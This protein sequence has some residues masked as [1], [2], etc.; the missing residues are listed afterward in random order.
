MPRSRREHLDRAANGGSV[1]GSWE[2]SAQ[3]RAVARWTLHPS[4]ANSSLLTASGILAFFI[5]EECVDGQRVFETFPTYWHGSSSGA[6]LGSVGTR[7]SFPYWPSGSGTSATLSGI[8]GIVCEGGAGRFIVP[9]QLVWPSLSPCWCWKT[10]FGAYFGSS[11]HPNRKVLTTSTG[12]KLPPKS[13]MPYR[14]RSLSSWYRE[15][16][17]SA[18]P[19]AWIRRASRCHGHD[20]RADPARHRR[21]WDLG[22]NHPMGV[23]LAIAAPRLDPGAYPAH[24]FARQVVGCACVSNP[25]CALTRPGASLATGPRHVLRI[26]F[27]LRAGIDRA[28]V[29]RDAAGVRDL[30]MRLRDNRPML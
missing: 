14:V 10:P 7:R 1:H 24:G 12:K 5:Y 6:T 16:G 26:L 17:A 30:F 13:E 4:R 8:C 28:T 23:W 18:R 20:G 15:S 3:I 11:Y 22:T 25:R 29:E 19:C 27:P 21:P 2:V 9:P